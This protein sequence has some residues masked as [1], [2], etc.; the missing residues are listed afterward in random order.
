MN[1]NYEEIWKKCEKI[2]M[3]KQGQIQDSD[4]G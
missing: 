3:N 2:K 4:K 1:T